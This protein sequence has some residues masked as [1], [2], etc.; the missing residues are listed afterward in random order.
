MALWPGW[1]PPK[2]KEPEPEPV[3]WEFTRRELLS[4]RFYKWYFT[5]FPWKK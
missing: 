3:A 2:S 5:K 4:L 1:E